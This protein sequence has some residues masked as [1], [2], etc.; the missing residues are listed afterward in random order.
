M[1]LKAVHLLTEIFSP[2]DLYQFMILPELNHITVGQFRSLVSSNIAIDPIKTSPIRSLDLTNSIIPEPI[3]GE[4]LAHTGKL[5]E[6][7]CRVPGR[8]GSNPYSSIS[9]LMNSLSPAG[10][11][12]TLTPIRHSLRHLCL[13]GDNYRWVNHDG[14][15]LDLRDF[16]SLQKVEVASSLMFD[17]SI[18][19]DHREGVCRLLPPTIK[20]FTV[21][22]YLCRKISPVN[23]I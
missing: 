16:L 10:V 1:R 21:R 7:F 3:L 17:P 22:A 19:S 12:A 11:T 9:G 4:I 14:S 18:P 20:S 15:R 6:L 23:C 13:L 5:Q 8:M 2:E